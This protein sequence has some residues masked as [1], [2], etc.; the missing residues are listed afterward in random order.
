MNFTS[1]R[2]DFLLIGIGLTR[3][4]VEAWNGVLGKR[5]LGIERLYQQSK[6]TER[7]VQMQNHIGHNLGIPWEIEIRGK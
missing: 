4:N 7:P 6:T 1:L 5:D 2:S 3:G